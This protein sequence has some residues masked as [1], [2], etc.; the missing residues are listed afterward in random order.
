MEAN[1][2]PLSDLKNN[3]GAG[4]YMRIDQLTKTLKG[5]KYEFTITELDLLFKAIALKDDKTGSASHLMTLI[6]K[7]LVKSK[8]QIL[9]LTDEDK[10]TLAQ[11]NKEIEEKRM[12]RT[13]LNKMFNVNGD[14]YVDQSEFCSLFSHEGFTVPADK[15]GTLFNSLDIYKVTVLNSD[16]LLRHISGT[17]I[18]TDNKVRKLPIDTQ[19][20]TEVETLFQVIDDVHN[21]TISEDQLFKAISVSCHNQCTHEEVK[22]IMKNLDSAQNGFISKE[23]FT[24]YMVNRIKS[25]AINAEDNMIDIEEKLKNYDLDLNGWLTN[26]KIYAIILTMCPALQFDVLD[27]IY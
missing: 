5:I 19:I 9:Q 11:L 23:E 16:Y 20:S 21:G 15:I 18:A 26:D 7:E 4:R 1:E 12:N 17:E 25:D 13:K 2:I 22:E 27:E 3:T 6:N 14:G 10:E 8:P 24:A